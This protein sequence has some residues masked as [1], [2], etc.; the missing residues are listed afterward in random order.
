MKKALVLTLLSTA[1]A[2]LALPSAGAAAL[3]KWQVTLKPSPAQVKANQQV[4]YSGT[5]KTAAGKAAAGTVTIQKRLAPDG[6]WAA[7]RCM[8]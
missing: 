2:L 5:V 3:P 8:S 6:A 1:V 7:W 4:T